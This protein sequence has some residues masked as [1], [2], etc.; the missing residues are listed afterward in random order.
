MWAT[1]R[2]LM[3]K[4]DTDK[5]PTYH[6]L[7]LVDVNQVFSDWVSYDHLSS[8]N[9]IPVKMWENKNFETVVQKISSP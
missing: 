5:S 6:G 4:E 8:R 7:D 3:V 1:D 9:V 2:E